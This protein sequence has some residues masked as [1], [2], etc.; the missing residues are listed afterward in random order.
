M[1]CV[2][3]VA[4]KPSPSI[5]V[6]GTIN[7]VSL[8]NPVHLKIIFQIDGLLSHAKGASFQDQDMKLVKS[9]QSKVNQSLQPN[10][11]FETYIEQ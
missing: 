5:R 8:R 9:S 10:I 11:F 7:I 2:S 1:V 4:R 6:A 3:S